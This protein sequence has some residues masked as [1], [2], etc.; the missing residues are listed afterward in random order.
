[1]RALIVH[2]TVCVCVQRAGGYN[3]DLGLMC[4][5]MH[6]IVRTYKGLQWALNFEEHSHKHLQTT[7]VQ[8]IRKVRQRNM[9]GCSS[10]INT[11]STNVATMATINTH[12]LG[13]LMDREWTHMKTHSCHTQQKYKTSIVSGKYIWTILYVYAQTQVSS[14]NFSIQYVR[15]S[16]VSAAYGNTSLSVCQSLNKNRIWEKRLETPYSVIVRMK[17]NGWGSQKQKCMQRERRELWGLRK[18]KVNMYSCPS[19]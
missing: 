4:N 3:A 17:K 2:E 16:L 12:T 14:A 5:T 19:A 6:L 18:K 7:C 10:C 1:M 8:Q 9:Q 13:L 15:W 11:P